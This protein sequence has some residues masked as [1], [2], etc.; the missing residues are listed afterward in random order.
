MTEFFVIATGTSPRQMRTVIDELQDLGKKMNFAAWHVSGYESAK[1]IVLDCVNVVVHVF[2]SESRDF[3]DLE[4]LWG[5]SPRIDW[6]KELGLPPAAETPPEPDALDES[7]EEEAAL[8][9]Q[10][11]AEGDADVDEDA[12]LDEPVVVERPDE[13][14]GSNSVEFMEID[15]PSKRGQKGRTKFPAALAEPE[16]ASVEELAMG[17]L[18]RISEGVEE[19]DEDAAALA[20]AEG[21]IKKARRPAARKPGRKKPAK[22][23][24][25]AAKKPVARK[26]AKKS[27]AKKTA[28]KKAAPKKS[29]TRK[30][31]KTAAKKPSVKKRGK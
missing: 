11:D 2:D 26:P 5:D 7:D 17:P 27:A 28:V 21:D 15:P 19:A 1:W 30:T 25:P 20:E 12:E 18:S 9:H 16:D 14:T 24:K 22:A 31:S 10:H 3:Y 8:E 13:S 4:L 23:K 29:V 6:R